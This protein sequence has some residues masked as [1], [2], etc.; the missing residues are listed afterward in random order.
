[1]LLIPPQNDSSSSR[2]GYVH[3][4]PST[5]PLEKKKSPFRSPRMIH[6][7]AGRGSNGQ[8]GALPAP[9]LSPR[10]M[11]PP[12][13]ATTSSQKPPYLSPTPSAADSTDPFP[14]ARGLQ[15]CMWGP[16]AKFKPHLLCNYALNPCWGGRI[17]PPGPRHRG[18]AGARLPAPALF[19]EAPG[20]DP[21]QKA[22]CSNA[23]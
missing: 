1:M 11:G 22:A 18:A 13:P 4:H 3:W 23:A 2:R 12:S 8:V 16:K 21:I 15:L 19:P 5:A 10:R 14:P 7:P 9:V 6:L 17:R 20:C